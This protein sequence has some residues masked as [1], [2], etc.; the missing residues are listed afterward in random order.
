ME[1]RIVVVLCL[2]VIF[3]LVSFIFLENKYN[4]MGV[5]LSVRGS[6]TEEASNKIKE[7]S[8]VD[9]VNI[10]Y[11]MPYDK[12]KLVMTT[13][14]DRQLKSIDLIYGQFISSLDRKVAVIG[15]KVA[16]YY[17]RSEEVVGKNILI[18]GEEYEV[19]GI[20]RRSKDIY[21]P[22]SQDLTS[23]DW[24]AKNIKYSVKDK[25]PLYAAIEKVEGKLR[26]LRGIEVYDTVIYKEKIYAYMNLVILVIIYFFA[27]Y[28]FRTYIYLKK[29]T[30]HLFNKYKEVRRNTE[31]F[32][33]I[34]ANIKDTSKAVGKIMGM[35]ILILGIWV[36]KSYLFLA[37]TI[38]PDNLFSPSSYLTVLKAK[39][40]QLMLHLQ[41]GFT[42]ISIDI[43][44]INIL[45]SLMTIIIAMLLSSKLKGKGKYSL[46]LKQDIE[47]VEQ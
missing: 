43:I 42:D 30:L 2:I 33:F 12:H 14:M 45:G 26:N 44:L 8:Q 11:W 16:D 13:G 27:F 22:F 34:K 41:N 40:N 24:K 9:S 37:D 10:S 35:L 23:L 38:I 15:D 31:W 7:I 39:Y 46:M 21:I 6:V 47:S 25:E 5:E 32:R 18:Y 19:I 29:E 4:P 36:A 1:I 20:L 28:T 17:F 3:A